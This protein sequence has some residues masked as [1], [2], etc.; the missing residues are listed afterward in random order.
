MGN[1]GG[2]GDQIMDM[3][4]EENCTGRERGNEKLKWMGKFVLP[5]HSLQQKN[6][7]QLGTNLVVVVVT[8][9]ERLL[10]EYHAGKHAAETPQVQR[11]V[12]QLQRH[13]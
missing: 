9:E 1:F 13:Q 7:D 2:V 10:A 3:G 5:C 12:I 8:M 4:W 11:V 6:S